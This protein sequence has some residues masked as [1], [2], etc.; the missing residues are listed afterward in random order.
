[1]ELTTREMLRAVQECREAGCHELT[2]EKNGYCEKHQREAKKERRDKYNDFYNTKEWKHKR[3]YIMKRYAGVCVNCLDE[4]GEP[5]DALYVHHIEEIKDN[6]GKR[7]DNNN[8]I[9]VCA[10]C[11]K[12]IHD[13][14]N[15]GR[16]Q[17][18]HE[19]QRL[20]KVLRDCII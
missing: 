3:E 1:M 11:H 7:L 15:E 10:S 18:T 8:L 5:E 13:R 20:K 6:W 16:F 2:R 9:P 12:R 14:Y 17:K 4:I 19:M